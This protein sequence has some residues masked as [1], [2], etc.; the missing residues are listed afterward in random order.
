MGKGYIPA[1]ETVIAAKNRHLSV[2]DYLEELWQ[3]KGARQQVIDTLTKLNVFEN[4]RRIL[5]IGPGSGMFLEKVLAFRAPVHYEIYEIAEDWQA[6][7]LNEYGSEI[8]ARPASGESL[9]PTESNSID[10][11]HAH[12]V[13]IYLD[14]LNSYRYFQ[15]IARVIRPAGFV[16]LDIFDE[17]CLTDEIV[18]QWL[19]S[20]YNYPC[21][22]GMD[23]V[24][25]F[26]TKRQFKL[27]GSFHSVIDAGISRYLVFQK[28]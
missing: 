12:G 16:V 26:F 13:F 10:L 25:S 11:V 14:F 23:Y 4:A 3:R 9:A 1:V 19:A 17:S 2:G 15:E 8:I 27:A 18:E 7:L 20:I 21:F 5:E 24:V 28:L 22:L 6:Y